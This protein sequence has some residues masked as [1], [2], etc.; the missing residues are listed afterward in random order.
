V[1]REEEIQRSNSA[2][3]LAKEIADVKI[4]QLV[5]ADLNQFNLEPWRHV[6]ERVLLFNRDIVDA[7]LSVLPASTVEGF[8]NRCTS[9][10]QALHNVLNYT[11]TSGD[12]NRQRPEMVAHLEAQ[13]HDQYNHCAMPLTYAKSH[14]SV[15]QTEAAKLRSLAAEVAAAKEKFTQA[16]G[17]I[18]QQKQQ[19]EKK[20]NDMLEAMRK[21]AA[22]IGVS[23]EAAHFQS[24][25]RAFQRGSLRWLIAA[26]F[27]AILVFIGL[28]YLLDPQRPISKIPF[29]T[30]YTPPIDPGLPRDP[31]AMVEHALARVGIVSLLSTVLWFCL[32]N[33]SASRH[34]Y[35]VNNHRAVALTTF[36]TFVAGTATPAVKDAVLLRASEAAFSAQSSGYL[37]GEGGEPPQVTHLTEIVKSAAGR[38]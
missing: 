34:N 27:A 4:E 12:P 8:I 37:K 23:Q 28:A 16:V 11:V 6:F 13:F 21:A 2:K 5:R 17:E 30:N 9:V 15:V 32:R 10:K 14:S 31:G 18:D 35:I 33:Y 7:D 3:A 22:E 29:L 26:A 1:T 36:Q 25:A 38:D 24:V 19:N 20:A